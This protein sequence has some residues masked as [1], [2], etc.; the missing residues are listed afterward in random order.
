MV[1][2]EI[3]DDAN[4]VGG[5]TCEFPEGIYYVG[6]PEEMMLP[7]FLATTC[8][9]SS[10]AFEDMES[11]ALIFI[12]TFSTST[13]TINTNNGPDTL[14]VSDSNIIA[15]MSEDMVK[16]DRKYEDAK[17]VFNSPTVIELNT[18]FETIEMKN[19]DCIM[20]LCHYD[21]DSGYEESD[22][23]MY[24]RSYASRGFDY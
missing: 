1:Y 9:L 12:H 8:Y 5:F 14:I 7:E 16:H 6:N 19:S 24:S 15:I 11:D 10:G 18:V 3:C 17:L 23:Q 21:M 2:W 4:D 20:S 13:F 22:E